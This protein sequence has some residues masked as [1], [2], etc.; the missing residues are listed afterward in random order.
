MTLAVMPW[1]SAPVTK[2]SS[3]PLLFSGAKYYGD[4]YKPVAV[5]VCSFA[6]AYFK[7][8]QSDLRF[9]KSFRR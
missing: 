5:L 2:A 7:S 8:D 6:K 1:L 9:E 3:F 4:S